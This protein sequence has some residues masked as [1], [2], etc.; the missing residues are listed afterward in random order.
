MNLKKP[1]KPPTKLKEWIKVIEGVIL[2]FRRGKRTQDTGQV[3]IRFEGV[4]GKEAGKF[5][6]K[7]IV[8]VSKRG[9]KIEGKILGLH[10]SSGSLRAKFKKNLPGQ[11]I[12]TKVYI[13]T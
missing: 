8:W 2:N 5:I 10:G 4:E 1:Y 12:G 11:A 7:K 13:K 6:G 3:I 9:R